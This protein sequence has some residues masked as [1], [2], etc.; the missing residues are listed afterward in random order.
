MIS[1]GVV[2]QRQQRE[3]AHVRQESRRTWRLYAEEIVERRLH[4][5]GWSVVAVELGM[6]WVLCSHQAG[7]VDGAW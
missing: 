3:V 2:G 1:R 5:C 4:S 6:W 7:D